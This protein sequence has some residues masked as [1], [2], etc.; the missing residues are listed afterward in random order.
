MVSKLPEW[1]ITNKRVLLRADLNVPI[2]QGTILDD[3]RLQAIRPTLDLI[4]QKGGHCTLITHLGEPTAYDLHLSTEQLIPWFEKH[5]Y[6]ITFANTPAEAL[7]NKSNSDASITLLENIRFFPGE[8]NKDNAFAQEL[9]QLG[10][11]YVDDAFGT[12]HRT[13][14]SITLVPLLFASDKRSIGLL[15]EKELR[16]L[17]KL[18]EH[19]DH[20]FVLV[21]G[22]SK[23]TTKIP[24]IEY[25]I[26]GGISEGPFVLSLSKD[27]PRNASTQPSLKSF[28]GHG[29]PESAVAFG[30]GGSARTRRNK[31]DTV[32]LC[33]ALAFTFAKALGKPVGKSLVDDT[34]LSA[35]RNILQKSREQNIDIV[36]PIDYQIAYD[37]IAKPFAL[38]DADAM[39]ENGIGISIGPKTIELFKKKMNDAKTIFFNGAPGFIDQPET[40]E[41]AKNLLHAI[42]ANAANTILSGGDSIAIAHRFGLLHNFTHISTGGG[43]TLTYLSGKTLPGLECFKISDKKQED[44]IR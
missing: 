29:R 37:T 15:V 28:G 44:S 25:F 14:T 41:G 16:T 20:P 24:L 34:L 35:C 42:T 38:V 4:L 21:L 6:T 7:N 43:A 39:P 40:V 36:L 31:V 19:P 22:G 18:R 33:P 17:D 12:L 5:H 9:A 8:K 3:T 27:R 11:Y 32:L 2:D 30:V 10:D 23:A 13:D 1:N 26:D